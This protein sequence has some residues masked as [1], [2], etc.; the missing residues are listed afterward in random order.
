[1]L[2]VSFIVRTLEKSLLVSLPFLGRLLKVHHL[3][4]AGLPHSLYISWKSLCSSKG[5]GIWFTLCCN[6]LFMGHLCTLFAL[7]TSFLV[8]M[9]S[10]YST[11]SD[12]INLLNNWLIIFFLNALFNSMVHPWRF[13]FHIFWTFCGRNVQFYCFLYFILYKRPASFWI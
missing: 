4:S 7:L 1:M 6:I 9:Y 5:F 3:L 12:S 10:L 13:L 2:V 11:L 8:F